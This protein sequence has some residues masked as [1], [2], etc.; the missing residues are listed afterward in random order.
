MTET[1]V[2][3]T[4]VIL[5]EGKKAFYAFKANDVVIPYQVL[6]ELE[7]KRGDIE[8]GYYA[9]EAL[10]EISRLDDES[11][12]GEVINIG[13][14]LG[15]GFGKL[16][17]E[18]NHVS[19]SNLPEIL[20]THL[21]NDIR[22]L[23]VA[24]GLKKDGEDVTLV[25]R[26]L[27]MKV[28]AK[29]AG[30][31]STTLSGNELADIDQYIESVP[32]FE[33]SAEIINELYINKSINLPEIDVPVN[34]GVRLLSHEGSALAIAGPAWS[35]N[36]VKEKPIKGIDLK[37][38]EQ[39]FAGDYLMNKDIG[40]VSLG[41]RAGSGKSMLA[42][43]A[44]LQIVSDQ[45]TPQNKVVVFRPINAVGGSEQ[46]LGFLPGTLDEKL[47]PIMQPVFDTLGTFMNPIDVKKIKD[48]N[49]IEFRS[50]AHARGSTLTNSIIIVDEVQ[51][52]TKS[53]IG[54]LLTRAGTGS[55]IFLCWDVAQIDAKYTGKYDGIFRVV[56]YLI[57]KKLFAHISLKKSQRSPVAEMAAGI[58]EDLA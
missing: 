54:T 34:T 10:K 8:L 32:E 47:A 16:R 24:H 5:A 50:I 28:L 2:I 1:F 19:T 7:S 31:K 39:A 51:N 22:I 23:A 17:I 12:E 35:F 11:G 13:I 14:S 25:T 45:K 49:V 15:K 52:L 53:T 37:G 29:I 26:D 42:L 44:A 41:G 55:R 36:L 38:M 33:V 27:P 6:K 58:L 3:D 9:R 30:V 20:T 21:S 48:N 56:R 40:V 57:G 43:A 46:E 4:S 18:M